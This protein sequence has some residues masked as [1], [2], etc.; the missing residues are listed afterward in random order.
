MRRGVAE[1]RAMR[2][3]VA[4]ERAAGRALVLR[5]S[6]VEP[7]LAERER[8]S[9]VAFDRRETPRSGRRRTG[10]ASALIKMRA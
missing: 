7:R 10:R 8:R 5:A 4:E 1:E 2:R 3:G 6:V 9:V